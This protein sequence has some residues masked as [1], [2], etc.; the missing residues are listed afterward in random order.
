MKW[1]FVLRPLSDSAH[2]LLS[3]RSTLIMVWLLESIL[4]QRQILRAA[5]AWGE[6]QDPEETAEE[7]NEYHW[8]SLHTL[9]LWCPCTHSCEVKRQPTAWLQLC[10]PTILRSLIVSNEAE[11]ILDFPAE[12]LAT[13][14]VMNYSAFFWV[15]RIMKHQITHPRNVKVVVLAVIGPYHISRYTKRIIYSSVNIEYTLN[16]FIVIL[17][18]LEW[19]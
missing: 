10:F 14:S 19:E 2:S 15:V 18:P 6:Q 12:Y 8:S 1:V 16:K 17:N 5:V 9:I 3:L 7:L 13:D 4:P 11:R